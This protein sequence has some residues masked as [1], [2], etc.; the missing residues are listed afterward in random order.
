MKP[1][2]VLLAGGIGTRFTPFL[3]NKTMW[4]IC[5]K[6]ALQHNIELVQSAG[7]EKIVVV[8]NKQN[9]QYLHSYQTTSPN[10]VYRLQN[11]ALGMADA[12]KTVGDLISRD[13][14]LVLN[15]I[16]F[17]DTNL[18]KSMCDQVEK[19]HPKLLVG[20]MKTSRHLPLGYFAFEGER[21]S[22]VVEKPAPEAEPSDT[23]KLTLDYFED[24]EEF[25]A[26]FDRYTSAKD[27]DQQYELALDVLLK[28]YGAD[29]VY[30]T[31][32]SKLKYP[33]FVLDV[34]DTF[35]SH[36]IEKFVHHS[37][38]ISPHAL[39]EGK[40]YIDENARIDAFAVVKG[41]AYIGKNV[42]IGNHALVR[43]S[44]IE[45]GAVVGFGTEVARSYVGPD[46]QLHH[47]FVGDSVLEKAV[48]MS[49]GTVTT[50]LRLDR[51]SVR[52]KL[53]DGTMIPTD[54]VK[55]GAMIAQG[56]FVGSNVCTMPG[57]CIG[58]NAN[59]LPGSMVR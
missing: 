48:N 15:S 2:A 50:N 14:I 5:G 19:E 53:P 59:I 20:G 22:G 29:I 12:L 32:W 38:H 13:P 3:T 11:D 10:L 27:K 47:A 31:Y 39:I 37:A 16:D 9:E 51:K 45:E 54:K 23:V 8:G 52:C 36:R 46:C 40:V 25:I 49:W 34:M 57:V 21:V 28:Q 43:H 33:F 56:V 4:P 55:L 18:I 6:T 35:L 58:A 17:F 24:P 7:I 44:T 42:L 26:L 30:S 41:P 1:T